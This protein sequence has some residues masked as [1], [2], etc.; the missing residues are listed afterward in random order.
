M[1][2]GTAVTRD[3]SLP[4]VVDQT[5]LA[6]AATVAGKDFRSEW[7]KATKEATDAIAESLPT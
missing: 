4:L 3:T 1:L 5:K 7:F 2:T 6:K